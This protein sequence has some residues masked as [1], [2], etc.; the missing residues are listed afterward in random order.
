MKPKRAKTEKS[1]QK[2]DKFSEKPNTVK[3]IEQRRGSGRG[4]DRKRETER[5]VDTQKKKK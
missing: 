1:K 2:D 3:E 4:R 5:K